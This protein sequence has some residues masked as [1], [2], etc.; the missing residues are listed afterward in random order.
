M[1]SCVRGVASLI[2]RRGVGAGMPRLSSWCTASARAGA[3]AI[4]LRGVRPVLCTAGERR[5]AVMANPAFDSVVYAE[6]DTQVGG[7]APL[8]TAP[9]LVDGDIKQVRLDV[10]SCRCLRTP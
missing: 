2:T 10:G 8:F 7:P 9:A 5:M 3:A 1:A 4:R 6:N